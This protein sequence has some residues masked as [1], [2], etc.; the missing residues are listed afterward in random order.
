MA[1]A[2][3]MVARA[4]ERN[5]SPVQFAT[6]WCLNNRLITSVIA[7]PRTLDQW[8]DY[9]GIFGRSWQAEDEA[10]VNSLVSPGHMSTH[11]F[12]DPRFP[13]AGRVVAS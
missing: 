9:L 1:V 7:G 12:T 5:L 6:L 11:G 8:Q 4:R 2:E 10:F 13:V 3:K